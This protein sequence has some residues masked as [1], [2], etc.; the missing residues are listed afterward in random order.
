MPFGARIVVVR[1]VNPDGLAHHTRGNA[2]RVDL[3][4]NLPTRDW[5]SRLYPQSE[6]KIVCDVAVCKESQVYVEGFQ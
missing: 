4:R 6:L 2:R 3:N 5:R 1:C